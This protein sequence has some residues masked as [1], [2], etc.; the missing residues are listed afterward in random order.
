MYRLLIYFLLLS[1]VATYSQRVANF[2]YKNFGAKDFEAY[3]FWVN[4]NQVGDINYSYKTPEGDIKSM[5]L[6]YEGVD[7]LNGEKAFKVLFPNNLRLYI[8]PRKN[9][10]LKIASL[11]GKYSKTFHWLYEGPIEGRGTFCEAC[12]ENEVE[13]TK[14]LKLYYL[15]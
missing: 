15:K 6:Q 9:N 11:D 2:A 10:T 1:P 4:A 12:A 5:K 8:I 3:G 13:A 14:M 7:M